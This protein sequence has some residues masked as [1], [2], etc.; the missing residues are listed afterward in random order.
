YHPDRQWYRNFLYAAERERGLDDTEDL[1]SPGTFVCT[2]TRVSRAVLTL[3]SK[4]MCGLAS[5]QDVESGFDIAQ[6]AERRR[7]SAFPTA[8]DR[9][10]DAYLVRRGTGQT[11]VA[12]YPWFT[13]WGRDT[14]IALRGLCLGTGRLADARDILLEWAGS[15]SEG[16]L[17]NPFHDRAESPD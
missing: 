13:D 10:A 5:M 12:G 16:M 2:L 8:L 15:A 9:A 7:R 11:L 3:R 17:P 4:P 14:F 1:A 6:A